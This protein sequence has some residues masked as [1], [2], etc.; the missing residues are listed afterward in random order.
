MLW[1]AAAREGLDDDHAA[2]AARAWLRQH[3][4]LLGFG[5]AVGLVRRHHQSTTAVTL[6]ILAGSRPAAP[7]LASDRQSR[8]RSHGEYC[9]AALDRRVYSCMHRRSLAK[10]DRV[11][12]CA[13]ISSS[14]A[15]RPNPHSVRCTAATHLPRFRALALLGRRPPQRVDCLVIPASEKPAQEATST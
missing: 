11:E 3:A 7:A 4:R 10:S 1:L 14:L 6:A 5:G 12:L 13:P 2:A 9:H 15:P 8:P